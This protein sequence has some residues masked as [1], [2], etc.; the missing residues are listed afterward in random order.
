VARRTREIGIRVAMGAPRSTILGQ[1]MSE[2]A[3]MVGGGIAAG[4][5]MALGCGWLAQSLLY[6]LKPQDLTT[7]AAATLVLTLIAFVAALVPAWRAAR[8]DPMVALHWE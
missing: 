3:W 2:S 4:I 6:G 8:L 5:P 7:A 1:F